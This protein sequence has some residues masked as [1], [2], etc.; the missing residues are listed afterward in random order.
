MACALVLIFPTDDA[1]MASV[2]TS[3]PYRTVHVLFPPIPKADQSQLHGTVVHQATSGPGFWLVTPAGQ[4]ST[5]TVY[6][7]LN[8]RSHA[9]D[10]K[11]FVRFL[12]ATHGAFFSAKHP[13]I[14]NQDP[15]PKRRKHRYED[16]QPPSYLQIGESLASAETN[17]RLRLKVRTT[18]NISSNLCDALG[19]T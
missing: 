11:R 18:S 16:K 8:L 4:V 1:L 14:W 15:R 10:R 6:G 3:H 19:A 13:T 17:D 2:I 5:S 9:R 12:R 7:Y